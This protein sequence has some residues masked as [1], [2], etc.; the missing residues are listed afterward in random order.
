MCYP[1]RT[2]DGLVPGGDCFPDAWGVAGVFSSCDDGEGYC[3]TP[4]CIYY[5]PCICACHP[6]REEES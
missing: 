2:E 3:P 6:P 5:G 1:P 4:D